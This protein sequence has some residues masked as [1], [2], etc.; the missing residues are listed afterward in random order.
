MAHSQMALELL[1]VRLD[2]LASDSSRDDYWRARLD[3]ADAEL[4]KNGIHLR[5]D[6]QADMMLLVDVTA[7]KHAN[8]DS[9][10]GM[11]EWLRL[12]R[13]ERWLA[14]RHDP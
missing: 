12:A 3:A 14:E 5:A 2:R 8:R 4:A 10:A 9:N 1:K 11:P 13:R 7:W 6:D